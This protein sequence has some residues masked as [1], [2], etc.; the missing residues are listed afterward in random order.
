MPASLEGDQERAE[1]G[2]LGQGAAVWASGG[3][4]A[5]RSGCVSGEAGLGSTR[6]LSLAAV[7]ADSEG[8]RACGRLDRTRATVSASSDRAGIHRRRHLEVSLSMR[9]WI[10]IG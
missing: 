7:V 3:L 1:E 6:I 2:T 9:R 5:C 4:S 8:N 10:L